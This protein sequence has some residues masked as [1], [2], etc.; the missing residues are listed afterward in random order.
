MSEQAQRQDWNSQ[1]IEEFRANG[2]HVSGPF[3]NIPLLL[4]HNTGARSGVP[5]IKTVA[6]LEQDGRY[7]VFASNGGRAANP[8]WYF[9]VRAHPY[10]TVEVGTRAFSATATVLD[11]DERDRVYAEMAARNKGFGEY[12]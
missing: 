7:Y 10:V 1:I 2:G 9:N 5:R 8:G 11:G 12:Q 6:Y 3:E 4:L